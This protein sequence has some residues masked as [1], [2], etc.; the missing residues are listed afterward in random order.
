MVSKFLCTIIPIFILA[1]SATAKV[2]RV[3]SNPS[4]EADFRT[5][6]AA[7]NGATSGDT[8]YVV[9]SRFNYGS[10]TVNRKLFIIGPGYFLDQNPNTQAK[11]FAAST[12]T[13]SLSSSASGSLLTGLDID[14]LNVNSDASDIVIKRNRIVGNTSA[15]LIF[16]DDRASSLFI[17]ENYIQN[18]NTGSNADAID[19]DPSVLTVVISNNFIDGT[20]AIEASS[21]SM[22][23]IIE[24]NVIRGNVKVSNAI[25]DNNILREGTFSGSANTVLNNMGN[26]TQFAAF[27]AINQSNVDMATVFIDTTSTDGRWQLETGSPAIGTGSNGVDIGMFGGLDPYVLS[28][29]PAI[30]AIY[31]FQAPG[32]GSNTVGIPVQMKIKAHNR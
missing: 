16:I 8:L 24:N 28:G 1:T 11:P 9:G 5:L 20:D 12:N 32:S 23:L 22:G 2:W 27:D 21:T 3:D 15:N 31:F 18:P 10:V 19:I 6:Q 30:P 29:I 4:N 7:N 17:I 14:F 13:I 26:G 25:F